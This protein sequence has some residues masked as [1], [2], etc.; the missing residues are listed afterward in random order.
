MGEQPLYD[1]T[2]RLIVDGEP[3]DI[4]TTTLGLSSV[5]SIDDVA[6]PSLLVHGQPCSIQQVIQIQPVDEKNMIPAGDG[7]L[8]IVRQHFGTETLY[9]AADRAGILLIQAIP[10]DAMHAAC[11]QDAVFHHQIGR[12]AS[13]PS[14]A[15]WLVDRSGQLAQRVA[16]HLHELDPTRAIFRQ[17]PGLN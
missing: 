11:K 8:M 14:L 9:N 17:L 12:V 2:L 6:G 16:D 3:V 15:G 4:H 7:A 10:V 1:A 13:H 5:R